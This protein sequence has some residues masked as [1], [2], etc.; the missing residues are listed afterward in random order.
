[1]PSLPGE[2]NKWYKLNFTQYIRPAFLLLIFILLVNGFA[3]GQASNSAERA[4]N[5]VRSAFDAHN[6]QDVLTNGERFV[7]KHTNTKWESSV[8]FYMA[9][10]ALRL[11]Q[12]DRAIMEADRLKLKF[13]YSN[14]VDDMRWI[15]AECALMTERWKN[16]DDELQWIIGFSGDSTLVEAAKS[17]LNELRGYLQMME[18]NLIKSGQR[19]A[20]R[21][22]IALLLPFTGVQ[23]DAAE[24]FARGF[25]IRWEEEAIG[26]FITFDTEGDPVRAVRLARRIAQDDS[27]WAFVGGLETAEAAALA[28]VAEADQVP[29]V[30]TSCG[31]EGIAAIGRY[32]FQ[33]RADYN[34]IGCELARFA[35]TEF[36]SSGSFGMA[37][38][39]SGNIIS[40]FGILVPQTQEGRQLASGFK[41]EVEEAG[42]EILAEEIYYPGTQDLKDYFKHIRTIGLRR[43]YDD[44]LRS[45]YNANGYLMIDTVHCDV[46]VSLLDTIYYIPP[47]EMLMPVLLS[48]VGDSLELRC[49]SSAVDSIL[50]PRT[51]QTVNHRGL[52]TEF[53]H[54]GLTAKF[55]TLWTLSQSFLDS[56]WI[57]DHVRIR[58]W[59]METEQEIDSLE[60][61]VSVFDA[62]L[63]VIEPDQVEIVAPQFARANLRT[64]LLGGEQWADRDAL[65]KVQDYVNG[66]VFTEPIAAAGGE[67]YYRFASEISD[68]SSA[69]VNRYH[70]AGER[71]ACM[72]AFA[73]RNSENKEKMRLSLSQI[74]DL[75]TW[76]GKVSFLMEERIDRSVGLV[77]FV[78]GKF[79]GVNGE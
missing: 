79:E 42:G 51:D 28:A 62:F 21:P 75:E 78:G 33:G 44:S 2:Q 50:E 26:D 31:V 77:R 29:F 53:D 12:I 5:G 10:A 18:T 13:P 57:D 52:T 23:S 30:T 1:V 61:P 16:A 56:L 48:S 69:V 76:S 19:P 41:R 65:R 64:Q 20:T 17:R 54:S 37:G 11:R 6:W 35:L 25:Q 58:R 22:R 45:F 67:D 68:D 70:L 47:P 72:V 3:F 49:Q 46:V 40:R 59:M 74:Y 73:A 43:A 7:E 36:P 63:L 27:V 4:Y 32:V 34:V 66:I 15:K 39:D 60:I 55:D 9:Q 14:Y 24:A 8:I 71:A 38:Q